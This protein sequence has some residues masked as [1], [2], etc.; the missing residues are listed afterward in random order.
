MQR[1]GRV[2]YAGD[3]HVNERTI[4]MNI[5]L[6]PHNDPGNR[7]SSDN[8]LRFVTQDGVRTMANW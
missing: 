1:R 4:C 5:I 6:E 3:H 7:I 8:M 2:A